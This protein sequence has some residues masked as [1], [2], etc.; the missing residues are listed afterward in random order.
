MVLEIRCET[1]FSAEMMKIL[2][3]IFGQSVK[4]V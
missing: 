4:S 1:Y 2:V 3:K